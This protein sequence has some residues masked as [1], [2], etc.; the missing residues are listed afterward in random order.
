[1][2]FLKVRILLVAAIAFGLF[3]LVAEARTGEENTRPRRVNAVSADPAE[4]DAATLEGERR[5]GVSVRRRRHGVVRRA[6]VA[7]GKGTAK[8]ATTAAEGTA[9]GAEAAGKGTAKGATVAGKSTAKGATVASKHTAK[10]A[11]SAGRAT[12]KAGKKVVD[13]FK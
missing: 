7:V 6:A 9:E 11:K 4:A 3:G 2:R 10:G 8:G 1:M 13:A 12:K 5:T